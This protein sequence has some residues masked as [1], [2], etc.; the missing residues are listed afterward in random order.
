M[1]SPGD[2]RRLQE[3]RLLP[4]ELRYQWYYLQEFPFYSNFIVAF[5]DGMKPTTGHGVSSSSF[6]KEGNDIVGQFVTCSLPQEVHA[7]SKPI[8]PVILIQSQY[9]YERVTGLI[10]HRAIRSTIDLRGDRLFKLLLN[11]EPFK[12]IQIE[13]KPAAVQTPVVLRT[14]TPSPMAIIDRGGQSTEA[15]VQIGSVT[16]EPEQIVQL[17][18]LVKG[19][20]DP[21]GLGAYHFRIK[22]D[23]SVL[24]VNKVI[25]GES[26]GTVSYN[27]DNGNGQVT[28]VG[29]QSMFIPGPTGDI[30]VAYILVEPIGL[31]NAS[32]TLGITVID[33]IDTETNP[34]P[35]LTKETNVKV[36]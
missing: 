5:W 17:P 11:A 24:K 36:E 4:Q 31:S 19:I 35:A 34:I 15:I 14:P 28:L 7:P 33:L 21:D 25:A 29:A 12:T 22:F 26:F 20:D 2:V 32:T 1:Q 27:I 16:V 3:Q 30:I 8:S 9:T 13:L 6:V 23:P 10:D 18:I